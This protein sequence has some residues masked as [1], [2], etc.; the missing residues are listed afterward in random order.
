MTKTLYGL[1]IIST[2]FSCKKEDQ[3]TSINRNKQLIKTEFQELIDSKNVKGSILIYD[4]Q[5]KR[6]Y[7]NNFDWAKIGRLPASTFKIPNTIIALETGVVK[8]DSTL[9]KWNGEKRSYKIWEQDLILR[10]AFQY[11]CVPCY[12][13]IATTIGQKRM[14]KYLDKLAYRDM[15]FDASTIDNFWLEG[16]SKI[17]QFQQINFLKR[18]YQSKLPITE[19]TERTLKKMMVIEET[20]KFK[21][22]GKTGLSVR[23]GKKNGW[24]VGYIEEKEHLYFFATN[25]EPKEG[26]NEKLFP[27]IRKEITMKALEYIK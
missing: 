15:K 16:P 2:L 6:Y 14:N 24:F 9:F 18:L 7:S 19:R 11:S 23:S 10:D 5:H 4:F 13:E 26:M 8:N 22:S 12:Q 20:E 25:I 27:Q 1:L 3:T 21:L 17:N